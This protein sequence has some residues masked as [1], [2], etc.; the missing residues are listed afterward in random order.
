[1]ILQKE[2][3]QELLETDKYM[4]CVSLL[5]NF[6]PK[7]GLRKELDYTLKINGEKLER[8]LLDSFPQDITRVVMNRY[9]HAVENL[10]YFT[11][12]KSI[13]IFLSPLV[14]KVYYLDMEVDEKLVIDESFEI[15][16]LIRSKKEN[17]RYLLAVLSAKWTKIFLGDRHQL[18]RVTSNVPDNVAAYRNEIPEK[19][20][21]FS[22][23]QKR[24]EILLDKFL[25]HTDNG[26]ALLLNMYQ[27]PLFVMGTKRTIGHFRNITRN[28][29]R[30]IDYIHGNFE[31][32]TESTLLSRMQTKLDNWRSVQER[33]WLLALEEAMNVR[34]LARGLEDVWQAAVQKRGRWLLVER[35]FMVPAMHT[36]QPD[37]ITFLEPENN[38]AFYIKDAVD[39]VMEKVLSSGGQVDFVEDG[40]LAEYGHI[41]LIEYY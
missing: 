41:A 40:L 10:N 30:V 15:R 35:H 23:E 8:M 28:G 32:E 25:L 11:H 26:L 24:K 20:A 29:S 6:E 31:E 4:P 7:M 21:N 37:K 13:A 22:D 36:D 19:V 39:D 18:V 16:D 9:Q 17:T 5:L 34:K 1:M 27:L 14:E 2:M 3:V 12:K 38:H 33:K